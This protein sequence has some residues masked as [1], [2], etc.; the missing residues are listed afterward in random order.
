M[1]PVVLTESGRFLVQQ[2]L[3]GVALVACV[4]VIAKLHNDKEKLQQSCA[5]DKDR[6]T[7]KLTALTVKNA[8][9]LVQLSQ[10]IEERNET[11][12]KI[13]D[14]MMNMSSAFEAQGTLLREQNKRLIDRIDFAQRGRRN[15]DPD[16]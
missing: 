16:Q 4:F 10:S 3:M 1:D 9:V 14:G 11:L 12:R 5:A 6:Y 13:A 15:G 7:E 2:G 8:E